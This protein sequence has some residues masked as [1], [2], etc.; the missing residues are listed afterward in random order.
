MNK[1]KKIGLSALAGSMAVTSAQAFDAS[2]TV[3]HKRFTQLL[4]VTKAQLKLK[5]VK[6]SVLT[7]ILRLV[8]QV[9]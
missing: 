3:N 5:M 1:F 8:V 9:S 6:V 2:V 4:K 7:L